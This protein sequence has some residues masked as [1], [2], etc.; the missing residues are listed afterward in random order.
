MNL[1]GV[2]LLWDISDPSQNALGFELG[3][4]NCVTERSNKHGAKPIH[5]SVVL[6]LLC[7]CV[8][9][10]VCAWPAAGVAGVI[11]RLLSSCAWCV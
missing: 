1:K 8:C 4:F 10:R 5:S 7:V 9:A 11:I 6:C 2:G 3:G